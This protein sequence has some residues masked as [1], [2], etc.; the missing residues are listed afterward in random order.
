MLRGSFDFENCCMYSCHKTFGIRQI[1]LTIF[2]LTVALNS[3]SSTVRARAGKVMQALRSAV[4]KKSFAHHQD[5]VCWIINC[6][7]DVNQRRLGVSQDSSLN[8]ESVM[9]MPKP[10]AA[11]AA[12]DV[13]YLRSISQD[14]STE[15][16][17]F[18]YRF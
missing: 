12:A 4:D 6:Y 17:H 3:L 16:Y 8:S 9:E 14:Y 13:S 1:R 2:A 18:G 11:A 10:V 15:R 7:D 5:M